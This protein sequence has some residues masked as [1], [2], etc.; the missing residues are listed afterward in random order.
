MKARPKVELEKGSCRLAMSTENQENQEKSMSAANSEPQYA[1][2]LAIDWA[3]Q[4]H[5]WSLHDAHSPQSERVAYQ[6]DIYLAA[7]AKHNSPLSATT[8][9][10]AVAL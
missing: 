1:A 7:L 5:A 8:K 2:F 9:V 3:D 6:E 4:K 10:G